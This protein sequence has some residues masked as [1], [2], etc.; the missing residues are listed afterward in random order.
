MSILDRVVSENEYADE[1][2][3]IQEV[4]LDLIDVEEQVRTVFDE[5][6]LK[7]LSDSIKEMGLQNPIRLYKNKDGRF[8]LVLGERR[9]RAV[10]RIGGMDTI[11]SI[12]Y[13]SKPSEEEKQLLQLIENLQREDLNALEM[14]WGFQ[15]LANQKMNNREI[16]RLLGVSENFVS[17][18]IKILKVFP[19]EWV[20][21][22]DDIF[23]SCGAGV[24]SLN[25]VY[26]VAKQKTKKKRTA[27]F[28]NL[29]KKVE[30]LPI[31]IDED[32]EDGKKGKLEPVGKMDMAK[33]WEAIIRLKKKN[34]N[35]PAFLEKYISPKKLQKLI[36]EAF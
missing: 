24:F 17:R 4:P 10:Q 3:A 12:V 11:S 31:E 29:L 25:E 18:G 8:G 34:Q 20:S 15:N 22:L 6:K 5:G 1:G 32:K 16:S 13:D 26:D 2:K 30:T 27:E 19:A 7:E 14:A 21:Q 36:D 33:A 35:D 28:A 9:F 23:K